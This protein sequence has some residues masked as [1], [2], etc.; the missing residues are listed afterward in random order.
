MGGVLFIFFSTQRKNAAD[1]KEQVGAICKKLQF[2]NTGLAI[3]TLFWIKLELRK[4]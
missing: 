1:F 3:S 4:T 2:Q